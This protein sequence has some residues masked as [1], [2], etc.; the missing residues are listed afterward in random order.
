MAQEDKRPQLFLAFPDDSE[1]SE[2]TQGSNEPEDSNRAV[3]PWL[4]LFARSIDLTLFSF[5]F[6]LILYY[7]THSFFLDLPQAIFGIIS[8]FL[9]IYAETLFL[10][11]WGTTPGKWL[12]NI[13]IKANDDKKPRL[14]NA[15]RRSIKVWFFGLAMGIPFI[16]VFT[17][18]CAYFELNKNK[19]TTWDK[20]EKFTITHKSISKYKVV[21]A[22][23]ILGVPIAL[24]IY[25]LYS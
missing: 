21:I 2:P 5:F 4:R 6:A 14:F 3:K 25:E 16:T 19:I 20:S 13:Q 7:V 22:V 8:L 10:T 12:L 1:P 11:T 17:L 24:N 15:L 23:L 18:F 9:W